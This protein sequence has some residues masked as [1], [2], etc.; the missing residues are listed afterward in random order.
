ME[1]RLSMRANQQSPNYVDFQRILNDVRLLSP[2]ED[3]FNILQR[4]MQSKMLPEDVSVFE[5]AIEIHATN[6][7]VETA[8]RD[9]IA[10][11]LATNAINATDIANIRARDNGVIEGARITSN[12]PK[13]LQLFNGQHVMLRKNINVSSGLVNGARGLVKAIIYTDNEVP[14]NLPLAVVVQFDHYR[15]V[16][17]H[18]LYEN[19]AAITPVKD[20]LYKAKKIGLSKTNAAGTRQMIPLVPTYAMTIHKAQGQ[21]IDPVIINLG[22]NEFTASLTYTAISRAV[23]LER[24]MLCDTTYDRLLQLDGKSEQQQRNSSAMKS[25]AMTKRGLLYELYRLKDLAITYRQSHDFPH[26]IEQLKD[27]LDR[28]ERVI[29]DMEPDDGAKGPR[30]RTNQTGT[31]KSNRIHATTST[32]A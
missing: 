23:S 17:C 13:R 6:S 11:L 25:M 24:L 21:T 4:R 18:H 5:S 2:T 3:T 7:T 10:K 1:L 9:A 12:L 31:R 26:G 8:N 27:D 30:R 29:A 32:T 28:I 22:D 15:G 14:P 20:E 16:S 19:C